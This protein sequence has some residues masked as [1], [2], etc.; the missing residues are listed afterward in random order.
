MNQIDVVIPVLGRPDN[1]KPVVD[2]F[3]AARAVA[4][5]IVF[6]V[7]PGD[8]DQTYACVRACERSTVDHRIMEAPFDSGPGDFARKINYAFS[9]LKAPWMFQ[10]ADDVEFVEGWDV[11]VLAVATREE[12]PGVV[13]TND[14]GNPTVKAGR[15]ATHILFRRSY[16]EEQGASMDGPGVVFHEGY[17]HQWVDTEVVEL[18]KL[19][20]QWAFAADSIVRHLHP[21]WDKA[22]AMDDTYRKGQSTSA[23]DKALY[24]ERA[25]SF[26]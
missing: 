6:V 18:A 13:G 11:N 26:R 8:I 22:V 9:R 19:R 25:R 5:R 10:A 4:S 14:D 16:V 21:F 24:R 3:M 12:Q 23:A 7:S 2:S 15:H 1:A 17:G 20:C